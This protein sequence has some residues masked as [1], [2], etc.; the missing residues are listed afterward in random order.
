VGAFD[1]VVL[2]RFNTKNR[3]NY[4]KN[5]FRRS[6]AFRAYQK[7]YHLEL[8]GV[9]TPKPIAAAERRVLRVLLNSYLVTEEIRGATDLGAILRQG[10]RPDRALVRQAAQ[11]VARIH[12]EGFSHSDLKETNIVRGDD[13]RLYLLDLDALDYLGR[14]PEERGAADLARLL[15]GANKYPN[16]TRAERMAFLLTYCR[17]R[18]MRRVPGRVGQ[19]RHRWEHAGR[20]CF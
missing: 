8:L 9:P 16:V 3:L 13:G 4:L 6:R 17:A 10:T 5:L 2:K 20:R 15:K 7:A 1:G 19:M 18:G 11:L 14:V 12:E